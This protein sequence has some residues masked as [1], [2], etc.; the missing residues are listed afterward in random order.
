LFPG[1]KRIP[2][3][4]LQSREH[5]EHVEHLKRLEHDVRAIGRAAHRDR[6][7]RLP[8][9]DVERDEL[10]EERG[11]VADVLAADLRVGGHLQAGVVRGLDRSS[12]RVEAPAHAAEPVVRSARAV[13]G[14]RYALQPSVTRGDRALARE[15]TTAGDHRA[16]HAARADRSDEREPVFAQ[17]RLAAD[18]RDLL[19]AEIGHLRDEVERFGRRELVFPRT[20]GARA[21][22]VAREIAAKRHFPDGVVRTPGTID[23]SRF[24]RE[25][26]R[27][28]RYHVDGQMPSGGLRVP[29]RTRVRRFARWRP[30]IRA[31]LGSS[32]RSAASAEWR[33]SL[34]DILQ[35]GPH[36]WVMT[37][38][39]ERV[40]LNLPADA[41]ERLQRLAKAMKRSEGEY[42]R[43]LM[44]DAIDRA[45]RAELRRK[46]VASRTPE[47][48]ARDREVS[49]ALERLRG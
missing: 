26:Q 10:L 46:L 13:D 33:G 27:Y 49:R 4:L 45:E 34:F 20:S 5:R 47:R 18:D 32:G 48:R 2:S 23:G 3:A 7:L 25:R 12:C 29:H 11:D 39:L 43:D 21:A 24:V 31:W 38:A 41:R 15:R 28:P 17:V 36:A 8:C 19:H 37:A 9:G 6:E 30:R 44:L 16:A 1:Q 40:N 42:A 22:V 14:H 35:A